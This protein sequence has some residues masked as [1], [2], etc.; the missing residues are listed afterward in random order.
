MRI[1]NNPTLAQ[2][3]EAIR[4][5]LSEALRNTV[6]SSKEWF[7]FLAEISEPYLIYFP[8]YNKRTLASEVA[9]YLRERK[10]KLKNQKESAKNLSEQKRIEFVG[11]KI[12]SICESINLNFKTQAIDYGAARMQREWLHQNQLTG[13]DASG[14][15][16]TES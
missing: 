10:K 16:I 5:N 7:N 9:K 14:D 2:V 1:L 8:D 15:P 13:R 3:C 6:V 12:E 11:E 4:L